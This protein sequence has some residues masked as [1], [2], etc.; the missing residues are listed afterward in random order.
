MLDWDIVKEAAQGEAREDVVVESDVLVEE[1]ELVEVIWI[2]GMC[3]V[4]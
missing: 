1:D 3:G 2:D 4:Y